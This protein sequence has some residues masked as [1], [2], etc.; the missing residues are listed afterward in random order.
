MENYESRLAAFQRNIEGKKITKDMMIKDLFDLLEQIHTLENKQDH[1]VI[2]D[3][4]QRYRW[5]FPS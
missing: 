4:R 1:S 3:I 5:D 2:K